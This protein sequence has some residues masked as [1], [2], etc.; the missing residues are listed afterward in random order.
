MALGMPADGDGEIVPPEIVTVLSM[1]GTSRS[2][3]LLGP[4]SYTNTV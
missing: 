4:L 3:L 1:A 2:P